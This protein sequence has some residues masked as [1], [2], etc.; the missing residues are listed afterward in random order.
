MLSIDAPYRGM[1]DVGRVVLR[2]GGHDAVVLV[3]IDH[4]PDALFA[5]FGVPMWLASRRRY[6]P[7]D[8]WEET[9]CSPPCA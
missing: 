7:G 4:G 3:R 2:D 5:E 8:E 9:R 6:A 1:P